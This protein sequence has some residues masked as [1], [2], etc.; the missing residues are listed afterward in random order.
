MHDAT[1]PPTCLRLAIAPG[2]PSPHLSALLTL[3]H[4][5]DP[6]VRLKFFEVED[7]AL[8]RGLLEDRYDAGISLRNVSAPSLKS[9]PLW[10]ES[11]AIAMPTRCPLLG[12]AKLTIAELLDYPIFRWQ[13]ET[14]PLLDQRLFSLMPAS[15]SDIVQY[16]TSFEMMALWVAAGYGVGV[17][18]Q[19]RIGNAHGWGIGMRPLSDGPYEIV[20]HLQ[21]PHGQT[22]SVSERF[23]RRALQVAKAGAA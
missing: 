17:S 1:C 7:D 18:A 10:S 4:A 12:Q 3:Q 13:A 21:R 15:K 20:A 11:M 2:V 8:V 9:Q 19:S 5:E 23:E 14:C 16:V 6:N 22:N